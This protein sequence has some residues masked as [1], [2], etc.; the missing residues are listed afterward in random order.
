[1]R[2]I[3]Y[4]VIAYSIIAL[5]FLYLSYRINWLFLLPVAVLIWM[6]QKELTKRD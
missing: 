5:G 2:K 4:K 3:N 6:N 1:M